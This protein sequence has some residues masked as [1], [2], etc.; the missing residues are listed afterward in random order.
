MI[1]SRPCCLAT[2]ATK[3]QLAPGDC[4]DQGTLGH[5]RLRS[6]KVVMDVTDDHM[7]S[8]HSQ[9]HLLSGIMETRETHRVTNVTRV[10]RSSQYLL[11][12]SF[13]PSQGPS[14]VFGSYRIS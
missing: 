1:V 6:G 5:T 3:C 13:N 10:D 2:L 14:I 9:E 11:F 8:G 12:H 4:S 7:D